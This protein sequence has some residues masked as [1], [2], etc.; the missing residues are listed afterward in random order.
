MPLALERLGF[1]MDRDN[2]NFTVCGEVLATDSSG[3]TALVDYLIFEQNR[4]N[5]SFSNIT[6][7]PIEDQD[8][9][10]L[11][12]FEI[13]LK[14]SMG[15][16][17][18]RTIKLK[19]VDT[20]GFLEPAVWRI[21]EVE[22]TGSCIDSNNMNRNSTIDEWVPKLKRV[23][24]NAQ[25]F[26][27]E[28]IRKIPFEDQHF[29]HKNC[30]I[31]HKWIDPF[32]IETYFEWLKKFSALFKHRAE[33][34]T[35]IISENI[36]HIVFRTSHIFV[37]KTND[38]KTENWHFIIEA[39]CEEDWTIRQMQFRP[40]YDIFNNIERHTE[41]MTQEIDILI[42]GIEN[43]S[44]NRSNRNFYKLEEYGN[45][46]HFDNPE[47]V[48]KH[49][50]KTDLFVKVF[51]IPP[52]LKLLKCD[53]IVKKEGWNLKATMFCQYCQYCS[54]KFY[55]SNNNVKFSKILKLEIV[56][57][58][59]DNKI[60]ANLMEI[61]VFDTIHIK[62]GE[63][64]VAINHNSIARNITNL[65]IGQSSF[66][67]LNW[68]ENFKK[69]QEYIRKDD[70]DVKICGKSHKENQTKIFEKYL[71]INRKLTKL[72]K[73]N[74][75]V[76]T[77]TEEFGIN[78]TI[79]Y[80]SINSMGFFMT[81]N[82]TIAA[83]TFYKSCKTKHCGVRPKQWRIK[84]IEIKGACLFENF[85]SRY[86]DVLNPENLQFGNEIDAFISK[87]KIP[88]I[89]N[90]G[91]IKS[92]YSKN[93]E[94]YIMTNSNISE[95]YKFED[96][97]KYMGNFVKVNKLKRQL[98]TTRIINEQNRVFFK[99]SMIFEQDLRKNQYEWIFYIQGSKNSK[100]KWEI[101][102]VAMS[103]SLELLTSNTLNI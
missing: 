61:K 58:M 87:V 19:A 20:K 47:L 82:Y 60:E 95:V 26:M 76:L 96:F 44:Q 54:N 72:S 64:E 38:D 3:L 10:K 9:T 42:R 36:D 59:N 2:L 92:Q 91:N 27:N 77:K 94:G 68:E 50:N 93:F 75:E 8:K 88:H 48:P 78:F 32:S 98:N 80:T 53:K 17:D 1:W 99:V 71:E 84:S 37:N 6:N 28:V 101:T 69:L 45:A 51:E 65:L 67:Y 31:F 90:K 11:F 18:N 30:T 34:N 81:E 40:D 25:F 24:K 43:I 33:L 103:P 16:Q 7:F 35:V 66:E 100:E 83:V 41:V 70:F 29:F 57:E 22:I 5:E 15:F 79:G 85:D 62:N 12:H 52:S 63:V 4:Y 23:S 46:I 89:G 55:Y 39:T 74:I 86:I 21:Q 13:T 49:D 56:A 73:Y 102:K 14:S 97:K